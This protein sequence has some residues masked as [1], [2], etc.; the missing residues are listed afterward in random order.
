[1]IE[2]VNEFEPLIEELLC[3]GIFG[4]NRVMNV[5]EAR[6]ETRRIT[7][8]RSCSRDRADAD[9]KQKHKRDAKDSREHVVLRAPLLLVLLEFCSHRRFDFVVKRAVISKYIFRS[10]TSLRQLGAFVIQPGTAL[11]DDLFL[12]SEIE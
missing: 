8:D 10:I 2:S 4:G 1:M 9:A 12:E 7:T 6:H 11:F 3:L 5:S